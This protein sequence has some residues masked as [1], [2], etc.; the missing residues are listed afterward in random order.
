MGD[1]TRPYG[2]KNSNTVELRIFRASLRKARLLSQIEFAHAAVRF[3]RWAGNN[4]LTEDAFRSWLSKRTREYKNLSV[5][6]KVKKVK[7]RPGAT[8]PAAEPAEA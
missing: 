2:A 6:L 4:E 8:T 7:P 3:C 1:T 5:F